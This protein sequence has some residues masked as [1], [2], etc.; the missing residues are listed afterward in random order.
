MA[1]G[2]FGKLNKLSSEWETMFDLAQ[3]SMYPIGDKSY[4]LGHVPLWK[5]N[6]Y[7]GG[8]LSSALFNVHHSLSHLNPFTAPNNPKWI[9]P[10]R[11]VIARNLGVCLVKNALNFLP[12]PGPMFIY[13][14]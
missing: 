9:T 14:H 4:Q 7:G 3:Q 10:N 12:V 13:R 5:Y 11:E 1:N 8:G 6:L 2:R